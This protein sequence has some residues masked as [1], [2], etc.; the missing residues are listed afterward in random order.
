MKKIV[1]AFVAMLM[2]G[3]AVQA[4][5]LKV[6]PDVQAKINA[7]TADLVQKLRD[8]GMQNDIKKF[9]ET[10]KGLVPEKEAVFLRTIQGY[11]DAG[12]S[13]EQIMRSS[14]TSVTDVVIDQINNS[15]FP[16]EPPVPAGKR[17][18]WCDFANNILNF[19]AT[20]IC[21]ANNIKWTPIDWFSWWP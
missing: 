4:A 13:A 5:S 20:L 18:K 7:Q 2:T 14:N 15:T 6:S 11:L 19:A 10:H 1:L 9:M 8:G 21:D 3:F 16:A 12:A 17:P